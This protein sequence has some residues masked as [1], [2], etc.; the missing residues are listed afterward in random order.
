MLHQG[1]CPLRQSRKAESNERRKFDFERLAGCAG[2][3][4]AGSHQHADSTFPGA[5]DYMAGQSC[6]RCQRHPCDLCQRPIGILAMRGHF[7]DLVCGQG[8][9]QVD[10][11]IMK[12]AKKAFGKPESA[13][14]Q[15]SEAT[16]DAFQLSRSSTR[17]SL[18]AQTTHMTYANPI[19]L[20]CGSV[21]S[22][23]HLKL[24]F[25]ASASIVS[26]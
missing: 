17:P 18:E 9:N 13:P 12:T 8:A 1:A 26:L 15:F 16:I 24:N 10:S 11:E 7:R 19:L 3:L 2:V 5:P 4:N 22:V 23:K 25:Q 6:I 21:Q 20:I 14:P